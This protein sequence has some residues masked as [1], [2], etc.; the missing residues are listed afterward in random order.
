MKGLIRF[1]T[2]EVRGDYTRTG[3]TNGTQNQLFLNTPYFEQLNT[4]EESIYR[5]GIP[6]LS[7]FIIWESR[8]HA[9]NH[10]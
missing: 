3:S 5:Y 1:I 10:E 7:W 2:A 9:V 6:C 4:P 8:S